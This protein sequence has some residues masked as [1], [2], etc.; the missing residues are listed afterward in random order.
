MPVQSIVSNVRKEFE[1]SLRDAATKIGMSAEVELDQQA[2][3]T[4]QW[5]AYHA[6]HL[7][8]A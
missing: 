3:Q 2:C 4:K 6:F 8:T 5:P 1:D 7:L